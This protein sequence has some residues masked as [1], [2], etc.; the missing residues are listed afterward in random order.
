[1]TN[2]FH[3]INIFQLL[4]R[5]IDIALSEG[6]VEKSVITGINQWLDTQLKSLKRL[7]HAKN[8]HFYFGSLICSYYVNM[9][10]H[11]RPAWAAHPTRAYGSRSP[12][13][14][15]SLSRQRVALALVCAGLERQTTPLSQN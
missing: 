12:R 11:Q 14:A 10:V 8:H 3:F 4:G 5:P 15:S 9:Y 7:C 1:M 13:F 6:C 2:L